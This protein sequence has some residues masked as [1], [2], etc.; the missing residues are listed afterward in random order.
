MPRTLGLDFGTRRIGVAL[1][2]VLGIMA[3]PYVVIERKSVEE[4]MNALG[5]IINEQDVNLIVMGEPLNMDGSS[6][7]LTDNVK[8]F[9][10][11]LNEKFNVE[12]KYIDE[13]LTTLQANRIL[14][15]EADYSREKR[16]GV[17]D[18]VAA[19]LILQGYLDSIV[20]G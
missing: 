15:E 18:K 16:K 1:S 20:K 4:D 17:R 2:D 11:K 3:C 14:I 19:A 9:A 10:N 8:A 5:K 12:I 7:V 13:R 6:G